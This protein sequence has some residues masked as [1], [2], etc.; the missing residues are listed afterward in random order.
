MSGAKCGHSTAIRSRSRL[1][2][3]PAQPSTRRPTPAPDA[4]AVNACARA[5]PGGDHRRAISRRTRSSASAQAVGRQR[6]HETG[7]VE[8]CRDARRVAGDHRDSRAPSPR[9][10]VRR[11]LRTG[12]GTPS[13]RPSSTD[14]CDLRPATRPTRRIRGSVAAAH[15]RARRQPRPTD[16]HQPQV[17]VAPCASQQLDEE[18]VVLVA[19]VV[20]AG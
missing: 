6:Q 4:S 5:Q 19:D 16:Q 11:T 8:D 12:W 1:T 10:M 2:T 13:P 14:H 3:A 18:L 15:R 7:T 9:S 20:T 17:R